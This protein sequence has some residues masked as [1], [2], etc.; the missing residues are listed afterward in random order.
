MCLV[1]VLSNT[2]P[3]LERQCWDMRSW[4]GGTSSNHKLVAAKPPVTVCFTSVMSTFLGSF[5][6]C[7]FLVSEHRHF[8]SLVYVKISF[9]I[10]SIKQCSACLCFWICSS[11]FLF[12]QFLFVLQARF[13]PLIESADEVLYSKPALQTT[14]QKPE[15][16]VCFVILFISLFSNSQLSGL[17][18]CISYFSSAFAK[19]FFLAVLCKHRAQMLTISY[20]IFSVLR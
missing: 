3:F 1:M 18:F 15:I 13:M 19:V 11:C 14:I 17:T 16:R 12:V 8:L 9:G 4:A 10:P 2:E 5:T 7:I 6:L 20:F